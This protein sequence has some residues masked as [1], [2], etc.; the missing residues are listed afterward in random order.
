MK[1]FSSRAL[2]A[3]GLAIGIVGFLPLS[4]HADDWHEHG[5]YGGEW[6][7][8]EWREHEAREHGWRGYDRHA[9]YY[10]APPMAYV[11]QPPIVYV[12]PQPVYAAPG[13]NVVIPLHLR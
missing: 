10:V 2:A 1:I 12:Q 8:H 7:E 13:L 5:G 3:V 9:G 6:H 11:Q 4:A